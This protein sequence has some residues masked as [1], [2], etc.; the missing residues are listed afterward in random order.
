L[1]PVSFPE[2][3]PKK[4]LPKGLKGWSVPTLASLTA[5]R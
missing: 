5:C 3:L 1:V 4:Q 2:K